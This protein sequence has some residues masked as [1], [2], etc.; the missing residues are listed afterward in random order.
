[1]FEGNKGNLVLLAPRYPRLLTKIMRANRLTP[2]SEN[3]F[4]RGSV[5]MRDRES[6]GTASTVRWPGPYMSCILAVMWC[7]SCSPDQELSNVK[8]EALSVSPIE[9]QQSYDRIMGEASLRKLF[10]LPAIPGEIIIAPAGVF[11]DTMGYIYVADEWD[12]RIHRFD[13]SGNYVTSYGEGQ[14]MGPG[15]NMGIL[16]FGVLGDSMVYMFE[17]MTREVSYFDMEG[18]FLRSEVLDGSMREHPNQYVFTRKGRMYS[19]FFLQENAG[20]E[21]F[22]SRL[23]DDVVKF[24]Q[25]YG[26]SPYSSLAVAGDL[27]TFKEHMIYVSQWYPLFVQYSPDGS[28]KYARTTMD[29]VS[30]EEPKMIRTQRGVHIDGPVLVWDFPTVFQGQLYIHANI[31]QMIDIYDAETGDYQYS[32]KLPENGFTHALNDRIYQV[33]DSTV[34]VWAIEKNSLHHELSTSSE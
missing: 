34:S 12:Y 32:I 1:M 4:S 23:G 20:Q 22:E 30:I 6:S 19:K 17:Y 5:I 31:A 25:I 8:F 28:M 33:G 29:H 13:A 18:S 21:L 9:G 16:N 14:G 10:E 26:G 11:A 15:E 27:V 24:G 3:G 2:A 7:T